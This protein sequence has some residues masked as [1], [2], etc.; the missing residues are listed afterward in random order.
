M[1]RWHQILS[2]G[3]RWSFSSYPPTLDRL[4]PLSNIFFFQKLLGPRC[5]S[6]VFSLHNMSEEFHLKTY[7]IEAFLIKCFQ[8]HRWILTP[9]FGQK[10]QGR[11]LLRMIKNTWGPAWGKGGRQKKPRQ[12]R[13]KRIE[14]IFGMTLHLFLIFEHCLQVLIVGINAFL[15]KIFKFKFSGHA[16]QFDKYHILKRLELFHQYH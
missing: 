7:L 12:E 1:R 11:R 3:P 13:E 16:N 9:A 5:L 6:K 10:R 14:L 2:C 4:L 15:L 8:H